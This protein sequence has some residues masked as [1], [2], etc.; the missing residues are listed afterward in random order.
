MKIVIATL[1]VILAI[2]VGFHIL[3]PLLG[4]TI[5]ISAAMWGFAISAIVVIS[6]A[7]LLFFLMTGLALF[8]IALLAAIFVLVGII[9]FPL[10][11]PVLAPLLLL[12]VAVAVMIKKR[13]V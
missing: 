4:I 10:L 9:V 6:V 7:I 5:A 8:F 12:M 2:V 3:L 11:I 13:R 1:L